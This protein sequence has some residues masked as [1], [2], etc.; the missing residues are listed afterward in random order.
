MGFYT[1]Q[2]F[3][4]KL[5]KKQGYISLREY[6]E[7]IRQMLV[8]GPWKLPLGLGDRVQ[9]IF[10]AGIVRFSWFADVLYLRHPF[11]WSPG[12]SILVTFL[13]RRGILD[14]VK[15]RSSYHGGYFHYHFQRSITVGEE[16]YIFRGRGIDRKR[17]IAFSKGLGEILER[18]ISGVLDENREVVQASPQEMIRRKCRIVYPPRYHRFLPIQTERYRELHRDASHPLE[19]VWGRNVVTQQKTAIPRQM[20]SWFKYRHNFREVLVYPTSSGSAGYFTEEGAVLRGILEVVERDAFLVHWLTGIAPRVVIRH[21]LP[22]SIQSELHE[23]EMKGIT[24]FVLDTTALMLPSVCIVAINEQVEIPKIVVSSASDLTFE[25]ASRKA[26]SEMRM[27]LINF[28]QDE[29]AVVSDTIE[30]FVSA[31]DR[32]TRPRY[33]RG[34]KKVEAFRWFVSGEDI[35]YE[36]ACGY[37]QVFQK[38]DDVSGLRSCL[39]VLEKQGKGYCPIVYRPKNSLQETLGFFV[40]QVFIPK[41]FPFYLIEYLGTFESRRLHEFA[42]SKQIA[43]WQLNPLPHMFT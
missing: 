19:W 23:F 16:R 26:I 38:N 20:T 5:F 37:D 29:G 25:S 32:E 6:T 1:M 43:G 11:P 18:M 35:T 41:A 33:W 9:L 31:L 21:T 10:L 28:F 17:G 39:S 3:S 22:D 40:V 7:N 27:L 14:T 36:E 2:T 34:K 12:Y 24:L 30:P 42:E 13:R 4:S 15:E 8:V